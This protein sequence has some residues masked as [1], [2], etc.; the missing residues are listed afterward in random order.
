LICFFSVD[1]EISQPLARDFSILFFILSLAAAKSRSKSLV[2][3]LK[4]SFV[5]VADLRGV[6]FSAGRW[7]HFNQVLIS[8]WLFSACFAT[9]VELGSLGICFSEM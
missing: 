5:V 1:S 4:L 7:S 3:R 2:P 9:R 8:G 6:R